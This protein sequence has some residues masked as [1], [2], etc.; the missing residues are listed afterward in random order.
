MPTL[1]E[2]YARRV[3]DRLD[4]G[5]VF[6]NHDR[7]RVTMG[8]MTDEDASALFLAL[9]PFVPNRTRLTAAGISDFAIDQL[10]MWTGRPKRSAGLQRAYRV[11][12]EMARDLA[13]VL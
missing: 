9:A 12:V 10:R 1:L 3:G 4:V 7:Q 6:D 13:R 5:V 11:C 2:P 8:P